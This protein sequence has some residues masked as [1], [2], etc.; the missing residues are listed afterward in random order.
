MDDRCFQCGKLAVTLL[1]SRCGLPFCH[2]DFE[3]HSCSKCERLVGEVRR[4]LRG[5]EP[6][7][8]KAETVGDDGQ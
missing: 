5:G 2:G 8:E 3:F 1:C 4:I 7:S 6:L